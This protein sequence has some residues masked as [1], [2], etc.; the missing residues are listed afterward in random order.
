MSAS[1]AFVVAIAE[2]GVI[3]RDGQMPWRL[4]SDLKYFRRLTMGKPVVMGRKTFQS[5]GKP[6]D[7]RDNIVVTRDPSFSA[8]GVTVVHSTD[9]ALDE[10]FA[11]AEKRG[12][13]EIM[14]IGGGA[15]YAAVFDRADRL[16]V[17]EVHATPEGDTW[18][19]DFD[20]RYWVEVSR[21]RF[22]AGSKDSA[23]YSLV[24]YERK[25]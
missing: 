24:V 3:G 21:Q 7:G 12:V 5:I 20:R 10:A 23:D 14:V 2:N 18:F 25:Q 19:P 4:S 1:I 17:T 22:D 9:E 11:L 8:D 13:D 6:L 15:I 16:Y